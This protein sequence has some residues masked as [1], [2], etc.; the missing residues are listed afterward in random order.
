MRA[1]LATVPDMGMFLP[2]MGTTPHTG[3]I[4]DALFSPVLQ[5]VLGLLYGQPDRRFQSAELIRLAGS[6]TGAVHRV[7]TRLEGVGLVVA[8]RVGNQKHYQANR[9]SPVFEELRGLVVKTVGVVSPLRDALE[10]LAP[11]ITAAFVYGSVAAGSDRAASDIDVLVLSDTLGYA[12]VYEALAPVE[13][14]LARPVN[15]TVLTR[16]EWRSW[17]RKGTAFAR[18][19]ME[20]PRLWLAGRDDDLA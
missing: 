1:A 7:L 13:R 20:S 9:A 12:D 14:V 2:T 6:G 8:T 17:R 15:P 18:Q 3:G 10:P 16:A 4:A 5:R 11:E 19:L